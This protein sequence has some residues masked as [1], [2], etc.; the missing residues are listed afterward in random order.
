MFTFHTHF[1]LF[2][3]SFRAR[4]VDSIKLNFHLFLSTAMAHSNF[5]ET[6]RHRST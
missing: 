3:I 1:S 5:I 6:T 2:A 4:L